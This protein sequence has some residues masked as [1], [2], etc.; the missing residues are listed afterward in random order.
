MAVSWA[1]AADESTTLASLLDISCSM[2]FA[3]GGDFSFIDLGILNGLETPVTVAKAILLHCEPHSGLRQMKLRGTVDYNDE[4]GDPP[5]DPGVQT[6][7]ATMN[8]QYVLTGDIAGSVRKRKIRVPAGVFATRAALHALG[9]QL[10]TDIAADANV[11][12]CRFTGATGSF[13]N[14]API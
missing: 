10:A 5:A 2:T 13:T 6:A 9:V 3:A 14:K 1:N 12:W 8:F 7:P 4:A 11:T